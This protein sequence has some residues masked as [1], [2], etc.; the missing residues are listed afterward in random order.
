MGP[1]RGVGTL[2]RASRDSQAPQGAAPAQAVHPSNW[3]AAAEAHVDAGLLISQCFGAHP[4]PGT[5][6]V[7]ADT[8]SKPTGACTHHGTLGA[9]PSPGTLGRPQWPA[10]SWQRAPGRAAGLARPDTK[11]GKGKKGIWG[12]GDVLAGP[13]RASKRALCRC[14]VER[15]S[16]RRGRAE[17]GS[18]HDACARERAGE[19]SA[20]R[21]APRHSRHAS[22]GCARPPTACREGG[23]AG[24][25][26]PLT[27]GDCCRI[28]SITAC[29]PSG[30]G[31]GPVPYAPLPAQSQACTQQRIEG[32][33]EA[34]RAGITAP[35]L[36]PA[37]Q[38]A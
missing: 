3:F 17:R 22:A 1:H 16:S 34:C 31:S 21:A 25:T 18:S 4:S 13:G 20:R 6:G 12:W 38:P 19:V 9:H 8:K 15:H 32:S 24:P 30:P 29:R 14:T 2:A 35:V 11:T 36:L 26:V 5:L 10:T 33:R 7:Q 37:C 23:A 27:L 28:K